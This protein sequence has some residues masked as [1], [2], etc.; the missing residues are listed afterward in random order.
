APGGV[1]RHLRPAAPGAPGGRVGN[2]RGAGA[3]PGAVGALG[4]P[5]AQGGPGA[6]PA[7]AAAGDG[8]GRRRRRP[9][10]RGRRPG[11]S[12]E[13][14]VVH[15]R[16]AAG[17]ARAR[18]RRRAVL[19]HGRRHPGRAPSL[20]RAGRGAA[21]GHPGGGFACG[22]SAVALRGRRRPGRR[23]HPRRRFVDAGPPPGRGGQEHSIPGS[24]GRPRRH[25]ARAAVPGPFPL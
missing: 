4:R 18:A 22:R 16:H 14:P 5:P 8:A 9:A 23:D 12:P 3:A 7:G 2:V 1:R 10:L 25:R 11:A 13:R 21:P 17:A 6:H 24:R 15:R 19:H 20:A